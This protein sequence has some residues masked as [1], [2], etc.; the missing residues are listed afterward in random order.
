MRLWI[1]ASTLWSL[2]TMFLTRGLGLW[3]DNGRQT[4]FVEAVLFWVAPCL[5]VLV[6]GWAVGWVRRGFSLNRQKD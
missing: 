5:F 1:V 3:G 4:D 2:W 6:L